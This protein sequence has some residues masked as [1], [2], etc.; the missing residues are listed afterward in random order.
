MQAE[1]KHL[2]GYRMNDYQLVLLPQEE[3]RNRIMKVRQEFSDKYKT[4]PGNLTRAWLPLAYFNQ[5]ELMEE[6]LLNRLRTVAMGQYP[7][8]LEF[9]DFGSFPSHTIFINVPTKVPVQELVRTIR[10]DIQRLVKPDEEHK[11]YFVMEPSVCCD[12]TQALAI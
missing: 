5:Y 7:F 3:L 9:R 6:R 11:P 2:P 12:E 4:T 10:H 8:R 1:I